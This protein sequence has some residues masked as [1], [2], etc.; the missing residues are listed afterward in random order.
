MRDFYTNMRGTNKTKEQE[1]M[2]KKHDQGEGRRHT[3]EGGGETGK[4]GQRNTQ[5]EQRNT[6]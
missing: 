3:L 1:G 4:W 6:K 2:N 5:G